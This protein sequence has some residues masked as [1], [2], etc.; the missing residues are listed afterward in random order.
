MKSKAL[1]ISAAVLLSVLSGCK[2]DQKILINAER[3]SAFDLFS[4][5]QFL[6]SQGQFQNAMNAYL[7][8]QEIS[9]RPAFAYKIGELHHRMGELP[10]AIALYKEAINESPDFELAKAQLSLAETQLAGN[11]TKEQIEAQF[12][13][14]VAKESAASADD[15]LANALDFRPARAQQP[16]SETLPKGEIRD[17]VFPEL[18]TAG[19]SVDELREKALEAES[20]AQWD[21]AASY[22]QEIRKTDSSEETLLA[23][24]KALG[25]SGRYRRAQELLQE[26]I[27]F[28]SP[29]ELYYVTWSN[30][31]AQSGN[32][33]ATESVLQSGLST[34]PESIKLNNNLGALYFRVG[35]FEESRLILERILAK[36]PEYLPSQYNL[37][38]VYIE[39][40][41][42]PK[43]KELLED[44][45]ASEGSQSGNAQNLLGNPVFFP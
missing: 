41:E 2:T 28:Q 32:F 21:D 34:Y 3:T 29:S 43:A 15:A 25:E 44:Y 10:K 12:Q 5:G 18:N 9:P 11:A 36:S 16:L 6:E 7:R 4:E 37:A 42:Y 40:K 39:L 26:N 35:M 14:D 1:L 31:A 13:T 19:F 38:L 22:Y 20:N 17:V 24:A 23:H 45:V 8:A 27:V 33:N 30:L